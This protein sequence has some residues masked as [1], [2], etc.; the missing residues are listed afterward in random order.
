MSVPFLHEM[1]RL[2]D[3]VPVLIPV[4]VY[5]LHFFPYEV[6]DNQTFVIGG[7]ALKGTK[8]APKNVNDICII[9]LNQLITH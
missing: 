8:S 9:I 4:L 6:D 7:R 2:N 3:I 5:S 1:I